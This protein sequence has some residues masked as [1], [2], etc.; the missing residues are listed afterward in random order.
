M[1]AVRGQGARPEQA[2]GSA[3][4]RDVAAL[5]FPATGS[6]WVRFIESFGVLQAD[7]ASWDLFPPEQTRLVFLFFQSATIPLFMN[8]KDVAAEAVSAFSCPSSFGFR[9]WFVCGPEGGLSL[10]SFSQVTGS[11]KTLAFVIPIM[12]IL[13]RREEKLKKM[14]VRFKLLSSEYVFMMCR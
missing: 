3:A 6:A 2:A 11:G 13:L 7:F 14:Q 5:G 4:A 1:R 12:E 10:F 8:N 9:S